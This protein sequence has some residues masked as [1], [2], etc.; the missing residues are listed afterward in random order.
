MCPIG[1]TVTFD[2]PSD[3]LQGSSGEFES[4]MRPRDQFS[5]LRGSMVGAWGSQGIRGMSGGSHG[6][7]ELI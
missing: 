3:D 7:I 1:L 5:G 2:G 4:S 6:A